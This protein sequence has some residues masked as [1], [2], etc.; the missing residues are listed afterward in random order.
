MPGTWHGL[1]FLHLKIKY[2]ILNQF[3]TYRKIVKKKKRELSHTLCSK[4]SFKF[5][6][7]SQEYPTKEFNPRLTFCM[8]LVM[9]LISINLP[10]FFLY[11]MTLMFLKIIGQSFCSTSC[12]VGLCHASS[13]SE[14]TAEM[15]KLHSSDQQ[16]TISG[17]N[18]SYLIK[19]MSA[20]FL[21]CKITFLPL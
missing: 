14:P 17:V 21:H 2:S 20:R 9:S 7:L 11:F 19:M 3:Q 16:F 8:P 1:L 18:F 6:Q 12:R 5:H 15:F 4:T 10:L 13:W